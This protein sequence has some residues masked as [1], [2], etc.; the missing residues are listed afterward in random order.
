MGA[1][2]MNHPAV[3]DNDIAAYII[4]KYRAFSAE[5]ARENMSQ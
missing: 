4:N 5:D 2:G 1:Y 3:R